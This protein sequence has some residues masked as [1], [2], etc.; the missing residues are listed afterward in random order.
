M[1]IFQ[2]IVLWLAIS[3]VILIIGCFVL[4][5][6]RLRVPQTHFTKNPITLS[7]FKQEFGVTNFPATASNICYASSR[8]GIG[9]ACLYRFDAPYEDCIAYAD[10]LDR[11]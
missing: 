2:K 7:E 9:G 1:K 5:Q 11:Y 3:L 10:I 4:V 8:E 6:I